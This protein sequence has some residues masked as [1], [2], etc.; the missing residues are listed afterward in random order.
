MQTLNIA[1]YKF[2]A[3]DNLSELRISFLNECKSLELKG[4][5][6]L[7]P[8]GVNLTLAGSTAAIAAFKTYLSANP[9]FNDMTFRESY[10]ASQPFKHL[11]VKLKK[12]IITLRRPEIR[13]EIQRAPAISPQQFKQ[14]LDEGRELTILDTRNDYEVELGT[15]VGATQLHI[16]DFCEF[17]NAVENLPTDKPVVMFC[18]GGVRCE[19]A[20][21]H[22]LNKGFSE[23]YQLD[24]GILN[25]FSMIGAAHYAGACFV[26]DERVALQPNLQPITL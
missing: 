24:G 5:I 2:I 6:L 1:S 23:V 18:T 4:T 9:R 22:L 21:L 25:Y 19:K 3:L 13:P 15:F 8:E 12:E 10:S 16:P 14:W 26:F 20:G 7:S 11:K 17:P